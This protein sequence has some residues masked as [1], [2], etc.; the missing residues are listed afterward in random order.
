MGDNYS[1]SDYQAARVKH[2]LE[3]IREVSPSADPTSVLVFGRL[4]RVSRQ[5]MQAV[6]KH[7]A[8]GGLSWAKF[9]LLLDLQRNEREGK[10]QGLQPS[11]L[12]EMQGLSRNTISALI[13]GL[14]QDGLIS[15]ELHPTDRR[16]FV[17]RLLPEGHQ[18]LKL[19]LDTEFQ[20]L[21]EC[22][23]AFTPD[24]RETLLDLLTRLNTVVSDK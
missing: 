18:L 21:T 1:T 2:F 20:F 19:K 8:T 23:S 12:S 22:F 24:E 10:T 3:F 6:E 5:M 14:E 11:E 17:I 16:K 13:A 15:R 9:R 7:L 4:L